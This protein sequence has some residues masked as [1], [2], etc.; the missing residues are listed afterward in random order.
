MILMLDKK[1]IYKEVLVVL[2]Y[3]SEELI[4]K[5]PNKVF[6]RLIDLAADSQHKV[7]IDVTRGLAEQD[8]CEESKD[9]ISLIYY[10]CIADEY[11]KNEL[12]KLWNYNDKN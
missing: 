7:N 6:N 1:D 11:E 12:I 8:I 9:I 2:G 5:I 10:S 4:Q 3:F